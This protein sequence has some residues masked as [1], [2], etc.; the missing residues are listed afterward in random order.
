[1]KQRKPDETVETWG[2]VR[3]VHALIEVLCSQ[4]DAKC[5][6]LG[7]AGVKDGIVSNIGVVIDSQR[8]IC[9]ECQAAIRAR[10]EQEHKKALQQRR[11]ARKA[12]K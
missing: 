10:D 9:N 5:H 8:I 1:M 12:I 11:W 7:K 3:F 4:C 2:Q 6:R